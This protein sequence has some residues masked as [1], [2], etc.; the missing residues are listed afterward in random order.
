[1]LRDGLGLR[2]GRAQLL[3]LAFAR[4]RRRAQNLDLLGL[5]RQ[6]RADVLEVGGCRLGPLVALRE[7]LADLPHGLPGV[8]ELALASDDLLALLFDPVAQVGRGL[9]AFRELATQLGKIALVRRHELALL[10]ELLLA[11]VQRDLEGGS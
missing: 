4:R 6:R 3:E 1:G 9:L 7:R 10:L 8:F 11:L 2:E 5:S